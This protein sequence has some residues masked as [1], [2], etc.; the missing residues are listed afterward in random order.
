[1][2]PQVQDQVSQALALQRDAGAVGDASAD[3]REKAT[4]FMAVQIAMQNRRSE[5]ACSK[6]LMDTCKMPAFAWDALYRF[7]RKNRKKDEVTVIEG[8]SVQMAREMA[9]CWGN[10]RTGIDILS[11]SGEEV[12]IAGWAWDI[13]RNLYHST[14]DSFKRMAMKYDYKARETRWMEVDERE[15]RELVNRRGA[16]CERNAILKLMPPHVVNAA[17]EA[18]KVTQHEAAK[19]EAAAKSG[20]KP[21]WAETI[22]NLL[23]FFARFNVDRARLEQHIGCKLEDMGGRELAEFRTAKNALKD[24]TATADELFPVDDP[25]DAQA[26]PAATAEA[27]DTNPTAEQ[28]PF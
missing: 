2:K 6:A 19:A 8:P 10:F 13:E 3:A 7:E 24:G 17:V 28:D 20:D 4:V 16:V 26:Q 25:A 1:M 12:T 15:F 11:V 14:S 27:A 18:C 5:A 21:K 22:S 23:T 9:R